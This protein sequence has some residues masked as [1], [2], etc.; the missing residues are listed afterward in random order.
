[1]QHFHWLWLRSPALSQNRIKILIPEV[2]LMISATSP[3][4]SQSSIYSANIYWVLMAADFPKSEKNNEMLAKCDMSWVR[5][6]HIWKLIIITGILNQKLNLI[7][8]IT[9]AVCIASRYNDFHTEFWFFIFKSH[10][11]QAT[12]PKA[13]LICKITP[14]PV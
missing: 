3:L 2:S 11:I 12:V 13:W 7:A 1:M 8:L 4:S 10:W 5:Q 6:Y 9:P 14:S